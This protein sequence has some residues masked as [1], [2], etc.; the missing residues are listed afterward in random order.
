MMMKKTLMK[1]NLLRDEEKRGEKEVEMLLGD[2][3][4]FKHHWTQKH[5]LE[6]IMLFYLF[7]YNS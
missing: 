1:K 6:L 7:I 5:K 2:L 3:Q 4:R